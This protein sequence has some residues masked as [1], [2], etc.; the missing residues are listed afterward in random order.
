[1]QASLHLGAG[2]LGVALLGLPLGSTLATTLLP[3]LL[4]RWGSRRVVGVSLSAAAV[5]LALIGQA[6][7]LPALAGIL[8]G[9][10]AATGALDVSMNANGVALQGRWGRSV[11][12]RLHAMWSLGAFIG[13]AFGALSARHGVSVAVHLPI[14]AAVILVVGLTATAGLDEDPVTGIE[15]AGSTSWSRDPRVL[16]L[17]AVSLAGFVVEVGAGDWGGVFLRHNLDASVGVAAAAYAA[18]A[19][20][21]FVVRA[22]GDPV[23][24]RFGR[25]PLLAGCLVIAATGYLVVV[26]AQ[27]SVV[28]LVGLGVVG[29][30]VGLVVPIAFVAAGSVEGVPAGSGVA[31]AAGVSYAGWT[32]AP[33]VIGG[34][35]AVFGLRIGLLLPAGARSGSGGVARPAPR[36]VTLDCD[37]CA[38]GVRRP[39]AGEAAAAPRGH[40]PG[41]TPRCG[42]RCRA[43]G[44]PGRPAR[45]PLLR[46][47]G[48]GCRRHVGHPGRGGAAAGSGVAA[49]AAH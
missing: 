33:P 2:R 48:S 14:A 42:G 19:L 43:A 17:S 39:A 38:A 6:G 28:A 4:A 16:V 44:V 30:G 36:R 40:G 5:M 24:D 21:H 35:A 34:L 29:A 49:P 25:R 45:P 9:F 26:L 15:P 22:T 11:F 23:V 20:P 10:G 27:T 12:G 37:R 1:M 46:A 47:T 18:F 7:D 32:T 13:A 3:R 8:V 31:T 41:R